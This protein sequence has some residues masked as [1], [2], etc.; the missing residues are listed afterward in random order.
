MS[1]TTRQF[2]LGREVAR[3]EF[4]RQH[5]YVALACRARGRTAR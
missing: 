5:L 3:G 1:V 2:Q 4:V